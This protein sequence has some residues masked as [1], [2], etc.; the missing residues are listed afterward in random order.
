MTPESFRIRGEAGLD[1]E[2]SVFGGRVDFINN[3]AAVFLINYRGDNVE[4]FKE[5]FAHLNAFSTDRLT[6]C[7]SGSF[8]TGV[9]CGMMFMP[10]DDYS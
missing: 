5:T 7:K 9:K 3:S 10:T 1:F 8:F 6:I 4:E 2:N